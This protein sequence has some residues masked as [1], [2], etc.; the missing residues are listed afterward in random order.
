MKATLKNIA[1]KIFIAFMAVQILNLSM[2]AM[3]FT[4]LVPSNDL[5]NFNYMNSVAEY[6]T[7]IL[8][9]YKDAFP[10]YQQ[11][12][13]SSKTQVLKHI[14]FKIISTNEIVG[15]KDYSSNHLHYTHPFDE[16]QTYAYV[17]EITPPPPKLE[18]I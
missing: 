9:N 7:E 11:I 6:V 18:M 12:H 13:S 10:E 15:L 8:L 4:P 2:D 16:N 17:K 14:P 1:T 5:G 3:D